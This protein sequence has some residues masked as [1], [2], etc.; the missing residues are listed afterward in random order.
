MAIVSISGPSLTGKSTL[1]KLLQLRL[2]KQ[3]EFIPDVRDTVYEEL[4]ATGIFREFAEIAKDRDYLLIYIM[5][6]VER[7]KQNLENAEKDRLYIVD[8]SHLDLMIYSML[9]LWYHYPTKGLQ[10][11]CLHGLLE[12]RGLVDHIYMTKE[13]D[14]NFP[15][16]YAGS[17]AYSTSFTKCRKTEVYYYDIF[18]DSNKVTVLPSNLV[19]ECDHFIVEDLKNRGLLSGK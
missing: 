7:Y 10:E 14:T 4:I 9:H 13:N 17:R 12:V 18:S 19:M 1:I 8:G 16:K 6:M 15:L 5:K 11:E 2:D 3:A